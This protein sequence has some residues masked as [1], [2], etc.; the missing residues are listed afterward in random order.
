L[1]LVGP[2]LLK[3]QT[4]E[5]TPEAVRAKLQGSIVLE[6]TV[7]TDGR[8]RDAMVRKSVDPNYGM[9]ERAVATV[10]QWVF[11]PGTLEGRT[12]PVRTTAMVTTSWR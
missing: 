5:L 6:I 11:E 9:D 10:S 4:L 1:G 8:V 2:T 7:G 3:S 12:V